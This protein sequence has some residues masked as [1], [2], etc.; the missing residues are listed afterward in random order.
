MSTKRIL[1][2]VDN[3][4]RGGLSRVVLVL[5]DAMLLRGH[6]VG[7]GVLEGSVE[8]AMP[9][10]AWQ[11]VH[12]AIRPRRRYK[13]VAFRRAVTAFARTAV[14][15]FETVHG[16]ADLVVAAGELAIRCVP[17]IGHPRLV[18][19]SHSSQ[20]QAAK[21]PG[22]LGQARLALK[23]MRRGNRLRRLL[24]GRHVHVVSSGLA[25][26]LTR[27][28]GVKPAS[29]HVIYN[30]FDI[31]AMRAHA[32]LT[33]PEA[34]GQMQPFVVG[35]G[36]L[37]PRKR[38]ARLID[39]FADSGVDGDLVLIGQG[40]QEA[41]LRARAAA[42][43]LAKRFRIL[44][45]HENH[46]ALLSKA[47]LLVATSDSEGLGNVVIEALILGVPALSTDCPHGPR[48]ILAPI[49]ERALV[50]LDRLELLP[51]R[52][53]ELL[54][55]PYPIPEPMVQRFALARIVDQYLALAHL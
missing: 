43:G 14:A 19:S 25:D 6:T 32:K 50:P 21:H 33:T 31:E 47:R 40:E 26:E 41:F 45:F 16:H 51:A 7:L 28:L 53:R 38:F 42:R 18:L 15:D 1:F 10:G 54:E 24:D 49:D 39:A 22:W 30:P 34:A 17:A 4:E 46:Y 52:L 55:D 8:E 20:L 12:P 35:V 9:Q 29:L 23:R 27:E 48:E 37:G 2:L 44:P 13:H 11:Q 36:V 3:L 5:A